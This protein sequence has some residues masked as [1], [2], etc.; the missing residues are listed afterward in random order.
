MNFNIV[1][2]KEVPEYLTVSLNDH[3]VS[4]DKH[5]LLVMKEE[6]NPAPNIAKLKTTTLEVRAADVI[7]MSIENVS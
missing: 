3:V 5:S 1:Y 2:Q 7:F 6:I 4:I